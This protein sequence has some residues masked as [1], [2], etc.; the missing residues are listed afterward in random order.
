MSIVFLASF[1]VLDFDFSEGRGSYHI[2]TFRKAD[3]TKRLP[4]F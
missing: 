2:A 1:V 3:N 4:A